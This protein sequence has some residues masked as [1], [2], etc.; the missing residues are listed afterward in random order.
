MRLGWGLSSPAPDAV[1]Q[2]CCEPRST[3]LCLGLFSRFFVQALP[4]TAEGTLCRVRDTRSLV[5]R[6]YGTNRSNSNTSCSR[7]EPSSCLPVRQ[8]PGA[9]LGFQHLADFGARKVIPDFNLLGRFDAPD[10]LLHEGRYR[11]DIDG[12]SCSRLHHSDNAF[13]PLVVWQTDDGTILNG[14]VGLQGILNFDGIDVEAASDDHVF[15]AIDDVKK[16]VG[17]Q[18]SD[19]TGM[20]PAVRGGLRR[21]F[22]VLV[23]PI[24]YQRSTNDDFAA[25]SGRHQIAV[26]IHDADPTQRPDAACRRQA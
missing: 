21:C 3:L 4:C 14:F 26:A 19:I 9:D 7:A 22:G 12:A 24:H 20:M 16:I 11:N 25:F 13:A 8:H 2:E 15:G 10:P 23:V 18:V 17:V 6:A 1:Q 5:P